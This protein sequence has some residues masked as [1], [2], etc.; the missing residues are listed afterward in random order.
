MGVYQERALTFFA[1]E[2]SRFSFCGKWCKM[3]KNHLKIAELSYDSSGGKE[4]GL[5]LLSFLT[6]LEL[7]GL[8]IN[9]EGHSYPT[10]S[11]G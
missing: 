2:F 5:Q 7:L 11:S 3:T 4:T 8:M 6:W 1:L 9:P 10:I